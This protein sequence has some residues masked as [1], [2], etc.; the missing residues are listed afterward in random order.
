M[1]ENRY[2]FRGKRFDNGE[3]ACGFYYETSTGPR[4]HEVQ[5]IPSFVLVS[6]THLVDPATVGQCTGLKDKNGK[7]IFEGDILGTKLKYEW[8]K[9]EV[10]WDQ[11][12]NCGMGGWCAFS[13]LSDFEVIGT[14]HDETID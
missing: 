6:N 1:M 12:L 2:L 5:G 4:I 14:I 10:K 8:I 9:G 3:W 13:P 7:L 11:S